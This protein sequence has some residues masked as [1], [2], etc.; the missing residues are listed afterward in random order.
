[1]F[2][3]EQFKRNILNIYGEI[4]QNWLANLP[5]MVSDFSIKHEIKIGH[6]YPDAS[7]NYVAP[8]TFNN[9]NEA[10]F[11][12]SIP[13]DSLTHEAAAL[14]HYDGSGC[15]K[16]LFFDREA[17]TMLLEKASPG[18]LLE[19]AGYTIEESSRFAIDVMH[20]LHKPLTE[21]YTFPT[22]KDWFKGFEQLRQ[23]FNG[24]T[25]PF[26]EYLIDKAKK[27]SDEMLKSMSNQILLHGDLHY[28]NVLSSDKHGWVAIDP[29]GVVG[30]PEFEIP[31]PR[32]GDIICPDE[33]RH[34]IN[35]FIE[36]SGFD[37]K[38]II[39]WLFSKAVLA[40]WWSY[41]DSGNISRRFIECAEIS[42][43]MSSSRM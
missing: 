37:R 20:R 9:G 33:I 17:G 42:D 2:V 8:A 5:N 10:V 25:G 28:A 34:N 29:K 13:N 43:E 35:C 6:C 36:V 23:R 18:E 3:P 30:E 27:I 41:E 11:K 7:F 4:G 31:L 1:M 24:S 32:L 14:R 40:A 26:S 38:K 15:V 22:L 39:N 12:C 21:N 16:L 19:N